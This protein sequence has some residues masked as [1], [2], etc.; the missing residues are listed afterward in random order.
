MGSSLYLDPLSDVGLHP[1]T[2]VGG[3]LFVVCPGDPMVAVGGAL[4]ARLD[5]AARTVHDAQRHHDHDK[6][7]H[8][9][10]QPH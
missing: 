8:R 3:T 9:H 10:Q 6:D 4:V 2:G 7:A 5:G 1:C